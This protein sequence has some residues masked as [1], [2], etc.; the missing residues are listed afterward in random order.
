MDK[1]HTSV[2]ETCRK[3]FSLTGDQGNWDENSSE[4]SFLF[5]SLVWSTI[6]II[7]WETGIGRCGS[8]HGTQPRETFCIGTLLNPSVPD[9]VMPPLQSS[10][11][12][13]M[14]R[15]MGIW[16][17]LFVRLGTTMRSA[18]GCWLCKPAYSTSSFPKVRGKLQNGDMGGFWMC[19]VSQGSCHFVQ[20]TDTKQGKIMHFC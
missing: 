6:W 10:L 18:S 17:S 14:H 13:L 4:T 3:W 20:N 5:T 19:Y 11:E 2:H 8:V 7:V 15:T 16:V 1:R 12:E 9:T